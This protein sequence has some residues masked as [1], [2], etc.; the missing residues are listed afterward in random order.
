[1]IPKIDLVFF[2]V[3]NKSKLSKRY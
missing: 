1:M 3:S 2:L